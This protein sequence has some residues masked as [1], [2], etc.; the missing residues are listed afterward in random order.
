MIKTQVK[1][2]KNSINGWLNIYKPVGVTSTKVVAI[3]KRAYNA[4]KVGHAGTLDP[5][6]EGVLPIALG[7][8]TKTVQFCMNNKKSY[9]FKVKWGEATDTYDNEGEVVEKS[10]KIPTQDEIVQSLSNF[11]GEIE[12][13]PPKY[14]AIKVDGKRAYDLARE[15]KE[16]ELKKRKVNIYNLEYDAKNQL[17]IVDC[18][19]G[20][21][22]RSLAN[23]LAKFL[24]T[25]G[26]LTY[27]KRSKVG[28]LS[29]EDSIL[30]DKF[31]QSVYKDN[32]M[33]YLLPACSVLDDI[34][35]LN[36]TT[37]EAKNI[38]FGKKIICS[39]PYDSAVMVAKN[40]SDLV[41]IIEINEGLIKPVR[42]FNKI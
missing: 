32:L 18:S 12:Q 28:K 34:P 27:L 3:V 17:F 30:L 40:E 29:C 19:K 23:D 26:H 35:V 6:A 11:I 2:L 10:D 39:K 7:E 9:E 36:V 1:N 31:K 20:T 16:F 42:V 4:K 14:S 24:Q 13:V 5:F 38:R 25:E 15:G 22:I 41:A 37:D 21:Y 8:A 33:D